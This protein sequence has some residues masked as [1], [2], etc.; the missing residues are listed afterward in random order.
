MR[1][2]TRSSPASWSGSSKSDNHG[3][4]PLASHDAAPAACTRSPATPAFAL[5][6]KARIAVSLGPLSVRFQL[7]KPCKL[8]LKADPARRM[9]YAHFALIRRDFYELALREEPL[10]MQKVNGTSRWP[11][12]LRAVPPLGAAIPALS[13]PTM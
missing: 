10:A 5:N 7:S 6:A 3:T 8:V 4:T 13:K 1:R 12:W 9:Y 2:P 11:D